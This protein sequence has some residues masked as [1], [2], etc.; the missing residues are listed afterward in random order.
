MTKQP[1]VSEILNITKKLSPENQQ[2]FLSL[3]RVAEVAER[4]NKTK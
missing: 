2:Y 3:V 4:S 1:I